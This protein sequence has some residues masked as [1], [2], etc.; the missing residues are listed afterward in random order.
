MKLNTKNSFT[1]VN[2]EVR[3]ARITIFNVSR[4]CGTFTACFTSKLPRTCCPDTFRPMSV[5]WALP[6]E[7]GKCHENVRL[8][9]IG[10]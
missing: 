6:I 3:F 4:M 9:C 10:S 1:D 5:N 2:S 8:G 7:I